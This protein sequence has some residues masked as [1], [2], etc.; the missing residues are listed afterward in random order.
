MKKD[1]IVVDKS[2]EFAVRII[3]LYKV[4]YNERKEFVISKQIVRSGTSIGANVIRAKSAQSHNDFIDE[5]SI[6]Q[7]ECSQTSYWLE[8][9][10]KTDFINDKEFESIHDECIVLLKIIRSIIM[11]AKKTIHNS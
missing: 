10:R 11:T 4:L 5:L 1:N 7:K 8:L 3:N 9:L 2:F 6:A